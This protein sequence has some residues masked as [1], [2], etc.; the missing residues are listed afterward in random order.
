MVI[1]F[2]FV[3]EP[4]TPEIYT[5]VPTL[6][7]PAA[8]PI[9]AGRERDGDVVLQPDRETEI[10]A[11]RNHDG[12][13][14]GARCGHDRL[15]DRARIDRAAVTPG[16]IIAHIVKARQRSGGADDRRAH[17]RRGGDAE[18]RGAPA[19][20]GALEHMPRNAGHL[21]SF[22]LAW[23]LGRARTSR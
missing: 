17:R 4:A 13:A 3:N 15:V 20:V 6:S 5:S 2:F 9:C 22:V 1:L 7:L 21:S 18:Q 8:L 23:G 10:A 11:R 12:A 14:A 16:A 19:D